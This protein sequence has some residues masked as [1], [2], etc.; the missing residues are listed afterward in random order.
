MFTLPFQ[1]SEAKAR[2]AA[3][4]RL[5]NSLAVVD[6][7]T[8]ADVRMLLVK[9]RKERRQ[10]VLARNRTCRDGQFSSDWGFF[11]CDFRTCLLVESEDFLREGDEPMTGLRQGSMARFAAEQG[12]VKFTLEGLYPL[13]DSRLRDAHHTGCRCE[14]PQLRGSGE[15]LQVRKK[16]RRHG[17]NST[18]RSLESP[19]WTCLSQVMELPHDENRGF[20]NTRRRVDYRRLWG[21]QRARKPVGRV[22][23]TAHELSSSGAL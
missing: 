16:W 6:R 14:A 10:E 21:V 19:Q 4:D 13:T 23:R 3:L 17:M 22:S 5:E 1:P 2:L 12:G 11:A 15:C 18:S 7:N 8:D 20:V 9:R